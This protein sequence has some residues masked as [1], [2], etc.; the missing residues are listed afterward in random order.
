MAPS[1]NEFDTPALGEQPVGIQIWG[2]L[3]NLGT[4]QGCQLCRDQ[5]QSLRDVVGD[6]LGPNKAQRSPAPTMWGEHP[7]LGSP[8]LVLKKGHS[9]KR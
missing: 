7:P 1:E 4:A 9:E 2:G 8:R 5:L 3:V 6:P